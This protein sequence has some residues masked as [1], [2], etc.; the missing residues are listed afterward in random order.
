MDALTTAPSEE[1]VQEYVNIL[2]NIDW[3]TG[4]KGL[5]IL[6]VGFS[7][8]RLILHGTKKALKASSVPTTL[9]T[10]IRNLLRILLDMVVILA[11]ANAIGIPITSFV[12]L[13]GLAGLAVSLAL[14][15]VLSNL[16]G[17]FIILSSHPYV[18]G[19]FIEHEGVSGT[20]REIRMQHT[21]LETPDGKMIYIP[22]SS[23]SGGRIIN[24]SETGKRRVEISVSASYRNTPA[25]VRTAILQAAARTEGILADPPPEVYVESYGESD[26]QYGILAW[27]A[28][29]D[30]LRIKRELTERLY[31]S[32][33]EQ[34][35]EMSYPHL[36]V[37][38][39]KE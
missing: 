15:G 3:Q 36:N 20:V 31:T 22:N 35:V 14:Q 2:Q 21:R 13:L 9:H 26:I 39:Q 33:A 7:A 18:V 34:K 5:A 12:T 8:V 30:F 27:T 23:L 1:T 6:V 11:A 17:G 25:Q 38:M 16:A 4:L 28:S 32:F 29:A 37:H 10:M 24:Y 19:H